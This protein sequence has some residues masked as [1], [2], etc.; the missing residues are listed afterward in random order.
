MQNNNGQYYSNLWINGKQ[1]QAVPVSKHHTMKAYERVE[2][3]GQYF[4]N[5]GTIGNDL[6]ASRFGRFTAGNQ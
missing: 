2:V 6:S 4:L 1:G 5:L 3:K